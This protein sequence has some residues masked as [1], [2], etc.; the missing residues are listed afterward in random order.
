MG[1]GE[2]LELACLRGTVLDIQ[3]AFFGSKSESCQQFE[4]QFSSETARA[5]K[6]IDVMKAQ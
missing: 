5:V 6:A 1:E 2:E 3:T 4:E